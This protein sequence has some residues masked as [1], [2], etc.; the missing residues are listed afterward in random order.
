MTSN[1]LSIKDWDP[2]DRPREK[3]KQFGSAYLT[4]AELLALLIGNGT[5]ELNAVQL[6]QYILK[7]NDND[8]NK[9]QQQ[10]LEQLV[11]FKGIG[12]VKA[13][14]IKAAFELCKRMRYREIKSKTVVKDSNSAFT[15][16]APDLQNL[17]HEE[18]WIV[19]LNQSSRLIEKYQLSRGGI[20]Q[21]AV[22]LRLA[23]KRAFEIGA[24]ALILAHNHP[25]G[26]LRPSESDSQ[27]TQK[28]TSAAKQVDLTVL[29]HLIISEKG[30]FS[31]ADQGLL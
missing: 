10:S 18:F 22:D 5:R 14:K 9:L 7:V 24:T 20:T 15:L 8:L 17:P 27:L 11:R 21:T 31:F 29:D 28:F 13:I 3:F 1:K 12:T 4:N 2:S 26:G 19:Y 16:L 23:F 6:M 30:Y 25:S